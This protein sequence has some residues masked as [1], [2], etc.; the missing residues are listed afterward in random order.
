MKQDI[1]EISLK[2][3][4]WTKEEDKKNI[5]KY[6]KISYIYMHASIFDIVK[7][8]KISPYQVL[9]KA[10]DYIEKDIFSFSTKRKKVI[11]YLLSLKKNG[12]I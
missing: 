2:Y 12:N 8:I 9:Q 11:L 10:F 7:T 1:D 3:N 5:D 4:W 6:I